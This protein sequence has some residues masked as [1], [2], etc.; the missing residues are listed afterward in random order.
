MKA[1]D[2]V[3]GGLSVDSSKDLLIRLQLDMLGLPHRYVTGY[4]SNTAARLALQRN[5]VNFFS[6]TTPAYFSVVEPSMV[7]TGAGGPDLLRSATTTA[8]PSARRR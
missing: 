6:E 7:K 8:R 4:R 2:L 5:E 3:A 1:K